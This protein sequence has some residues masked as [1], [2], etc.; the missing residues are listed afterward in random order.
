MK[1]NQDI[2]S[3][4]KKKLED[5][6]NSP[7]DFVWDDIEKKLKKKRRRLLFWY[8]TFGLGILIV[9]LFIFNPF[10]SLNESQHH[11]LNTQE[12]PLE[13]VEQETEIK[14]SANANF[15]VENNEDANIISDT[16]ST[17]NSN[18]EHNNSNQQT[19]TNSSTKNQSSTTNVSATINSKTQDNVSKQYN[20]NS[21]NAL[22][23]RV[24]SEKQQLDNVVVNKNKI[25]TI[26][27]P[28]MVSITETKASNSLNGSISNNQTAL[29]SSQS[30]TPTR[31]K[32]ALAE[33]SIERAK[34]S[35]LNIDNEVLAISED[36]EKIEEAL[37]KDEKVKDSLP[38]RKVRWSINPQ[39]IQSNYGAFKTKTTDNTSTNYGILLGVRMTKNT[40]L[41]FG[42]KKLDLMQT[43]DDVPNSVSFLEI[44]LE[45]KYFFRD[46][47]FNPYLT[48]GISYFMFESSS[49]DNPVNLEYGDHFSLNLGLG[50]EHKLFDRFY[51]NLESN[52]N[53]QIKPI[54]SNINYT[55]YIFSIGTGIDYR[56]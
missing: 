53:Y 31:D 6:H 18:L 17:S 24:T 22:Q 37:E 13:L 33:S 16:N 2:G 7:D 56:F 55:P 23:N 27:Q 25:D 11:N 15:K 3:A 51:I 50:L 46:K 10:N 44:P 54:T 39:L 28:S 30:T 5:L 42:V 20:S 41:R 26:S 47:N 34:D 36:K 45:V 40:F 21:K 52:F 14:T 29:K 4:F 49:S 43:V 48:G 38:E 1:T 19:H 35:L 32:N 12:Q 8:F 9:S